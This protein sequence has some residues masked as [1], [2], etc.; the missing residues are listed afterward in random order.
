MSRLLASAQVRL[1]GL[2]KLENKVVILEADNAELRHKAT[3]ATREAEARQ[4]DVA[5]LKELKKQMPNGTGIN[6]S[7]PRNSLKPCV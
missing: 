6:T 3:L 5:E 2:E 7:S 4:H 1:E